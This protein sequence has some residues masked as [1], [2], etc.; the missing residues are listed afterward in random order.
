MA[1]YIRVV[2][3]SSSDNITES[4]LSSACEAL[5][6]VAI[7][8]QSSSSNTIAEFSDAPVSTDSLFF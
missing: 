8:G 6:D 1:K 4:S 2:V 3:L 7:L 5:T